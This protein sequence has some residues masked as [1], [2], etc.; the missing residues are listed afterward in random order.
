[1]QRCQLKLVICGRW[2]H[3]SKVIHRLGVGYCAVLSVVRKM[4]EAKV[5]VSVEQHIIIRFLTKQGR[6][7]SEIFKF[8]SHQHMHFFIQLRIS[9][10][11]YIK[12]T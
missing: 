2:K 4:S 10:L 8:C 3:R 6:K 5:H 7:P 12:I 11:S 9:L 1:M